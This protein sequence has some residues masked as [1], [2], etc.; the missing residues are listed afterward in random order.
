MPTR[1]AGRGVACRKNPRSLFGDVSRLPTEVVTTTGY[2]AFEEEADMTLMKLV[3]SA[4]SIFISGPNAH[5]HSYWTEN[6]TTQ[7]RFDKLEE[8]EYT[9]MIVEMDEFTNTF[10]N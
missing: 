6:A 8:S 3:E 2:R 1:A 4:K 7:R 10:R 5:V 9:S